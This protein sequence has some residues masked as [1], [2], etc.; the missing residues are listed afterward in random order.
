M[1]SRDLYH[2]K[3]RDEQKFTDGQDTFVIVK[4]IKYVQNTRLEKVTYKVFNTYI[5]NYYEITSNIEL[6][7]LMLDI[8]HISQKLNELRLAKS[9]NEYSDL[10]YKLK[11]DD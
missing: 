11:M 6:K 4:G 3:S 1:Y 10:Y 8:P 5:E 7:L 2:I 9:I